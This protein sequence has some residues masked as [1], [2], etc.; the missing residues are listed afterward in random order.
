[1][2]KTIEQHR[3]I[4]Y[5]AECEMWYVAAA[6]KLENPILKARALENAQWHH[7]HVDALR[8]ESKSA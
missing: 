6:A 3:N 2:A 1:M 7:R 8:K 5:H 4:V